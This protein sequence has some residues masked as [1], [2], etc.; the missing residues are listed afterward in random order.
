MKNIITSI[1]VWICVKLNICII[2]N[3][4]I[5]IDNNYNRGQIVPINDFLIPLFK[6]NEA[7]NCIIK[8]SEKIEINKN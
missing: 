7:K 1:I 3:F 2:V 5:T 6:T 4:K 8:T